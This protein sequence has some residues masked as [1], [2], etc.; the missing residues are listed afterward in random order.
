VLVLSRKKDESVVLDLYAWAMSL[1]GFEPNRMTH[2]EFLDKCRAEVMV[3]DIR[4]DKVRLG[5]D[6]AKE[7]PVNRQEIHDKIHGIVR[8]PVTH[9]LEDE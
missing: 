9:K 5:L 8:G 1:Y 7:M 6:I 3:V 2:K 4:G